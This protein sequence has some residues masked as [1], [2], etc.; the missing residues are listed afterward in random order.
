MCGLLIEWRHLRWLWETFIV[1]HLSP[2]FYNAIFVQLCSN[3]STDNASHGPAIAEFTV[4]KVIIKYSFSL[5]D[6]LEIFMLQKAF[7]EWSKWIAVR[8]NH[9]KQM[10]QNVRPVIKRIK[11][12]TSQNERLYA[13]T[14][15]IQELER[16]TKKDVATKRPRSRDRWFDSQSLTDGIIQTVKRR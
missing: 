10:L 15:S 13:C 11:L 16:R 12:E 9:S 7:T 4:V 8:D 6:A 5:Y 14:C 3:I 2:A 1:M